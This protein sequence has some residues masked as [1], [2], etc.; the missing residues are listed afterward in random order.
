M[1]YISTQGNLRFALQQEEELQL[2]KFLMNC[3]AS[4]VFW[5][6]QI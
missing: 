4:A 2:T 6:D 5:V 3:A 1:N